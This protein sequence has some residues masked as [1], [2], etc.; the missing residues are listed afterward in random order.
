MRLHVVHGEEH[1]P[2]SEI[3]GD[4][5]HPLERSCPPAPHIAQ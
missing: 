3:K 4:V 2:G 1:W 5:S